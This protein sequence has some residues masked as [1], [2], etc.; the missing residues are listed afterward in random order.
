[1]LAL[2]VMQLP[3][4]TK[5]SGCFPTGPCFLPFEIEILSGKND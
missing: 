4:K 2:E 1:M 3:L 5:V